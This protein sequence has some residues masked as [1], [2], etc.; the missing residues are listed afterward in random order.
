MAISPR[1]VYWRLIRL[2]VVVSCLSV[3][4]GDMSCIVGSRE[5]SQ[6]IRNYRMHAGVFYRVGAPPK[7][8]WAEVV[9]VGDLE[10]GLYLVD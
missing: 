1:L 3:A 5:I 2:F 7:S 10:G 6:N 9:L 8:F 4:T